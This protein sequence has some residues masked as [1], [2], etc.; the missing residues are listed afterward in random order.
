MDG[1]LDQL[2]ADRAC[3][4]RGVDVALRDVDVHLVPSVV[5]G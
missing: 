1:S 2:C 5:D 3:E 4:S